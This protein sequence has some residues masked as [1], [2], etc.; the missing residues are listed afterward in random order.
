MMLRRRTDGGIV[1]WMETTLDTNKIPSGTH[2]T[3]NEVMTAAEVADLLHLPVSTVYYL[4]RLG[5]LP[6]RR[7]GRTWR[8]LRSRLEECLDG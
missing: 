1:W 6:G 7:L 5:E 2:F 3:R 4:A 8:F